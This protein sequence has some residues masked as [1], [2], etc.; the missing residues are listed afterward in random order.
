VN[1]LFFPVFNFAGAP[2]EGTRAC[3]IKWRK[4]ITNENSAFGLSKSHVHL[5][6]RVAWALKKIR[7]SPYKVIR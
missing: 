5:L 2:R 3:K 7:A 6:K 4:K 1:V